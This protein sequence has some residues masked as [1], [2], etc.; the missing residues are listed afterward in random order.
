MIIFTCFRSK[1]ANLPDYLEKN[2]QIQITIY[3]KIFLLAKLQIC[4]QCCKS[5]DIVLS[6]A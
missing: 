4:S 5:I 3:F 2:M 6:E 1:P